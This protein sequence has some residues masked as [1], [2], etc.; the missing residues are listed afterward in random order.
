M[1]LAIAFFLNLVAF[2]ALG[3]HGAVITSDGHENILIV[4]IIYLTINAYYILRMSLSLS[5]MGRGTMIMV[6]ILNL[7][8]LLFIIINMI[9]FYTNP[10][11]ITVHESEMYERYKYISIVFWI[12]LATWPI[13]TIFAVRQNGKNR[14]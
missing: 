14:K 10:H 13:S 12:I 9:T 3:R 4:P 7:A 8:C 1:W 6:V 2:L 5:D 11:N